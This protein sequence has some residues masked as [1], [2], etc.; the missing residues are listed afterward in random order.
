MGKSQVKI[1]IFRILTETQPESFSA[2][3]QGGVN[4]KNEE[5]ASTAP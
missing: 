4:K 2:W 1:N 5:I 3:M